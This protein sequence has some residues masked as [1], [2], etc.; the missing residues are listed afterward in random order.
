MSGYRLGAAAKAAGHR[1]HVHESLGSTNTQAMDLARQGERG[2]LWVVALRQEAG[3]GRRGSHWAS[4]PGNLTASLLWP[5]SDVDPVQVPSLGFVAGVALIAALKRTI[6]PSHPEQPIKS[7][8]PEAP[9][10]SGGGLQFAH[11][12]L[13]PCFEAAGA[14]C[15]RLKWPNDVLVSGAKLAGL[16]LEAETHPGGRRSAVIGFGVNVAASPQ[17]LPYSA[18]SLS[19]SSHD[20]RAEDLF[21]YL[22]DEIVAAARLWNRGCGFSSIRRLWLNDAAGIGAPV[23][24]RVGGEIVHGIFET[25]D[26]AGRLVVRSD[27]GTRRTVTAG[28]VHLGSAATAA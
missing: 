16:L 25:I 12:P 14:S 23:S 20:T 18:T 3:R 24:V 9:E 5:V 11:D 26:E 17:D 2:P 1:L 27:D 8:H 13:E 7:P 22:S 21:D 4:L 15:F 28:E 10:R 19:Q 6:R